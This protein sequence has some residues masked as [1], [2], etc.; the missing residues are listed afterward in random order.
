MDDVA[1]LTIRLARPADLL[2]LDALF[3][4]SYPFLLK[5]D[6]PPSVLV[7]A[8]PLI[9]KANPRLLGS[10]T[11]YVA[12]REGC[13]IGAGGWSW[14]G[15]QGGPSPLNMAHVRHLVTDAAHVRQGVARCLMGYAMAKAVQGGARV[16]CC[17]STRTAVPFYRALGFDVLGEVNITLKPGI[18]FP[19]VDMRC[20][21]G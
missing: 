11:Y 20:F 1:Q 3:A 7:T 17:Q 6:Y 4:R 5:H 18:T 14:A 12:L 13:I 19:A 10:G 15:P 8:L 16:L 9:S 21:I 2:E